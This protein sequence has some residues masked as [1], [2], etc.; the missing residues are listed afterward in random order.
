MESERKGQQSRARERD[1]RYHY[2]LG[3]FRCGE[4]RR[5]LMAGRGKGRV[6]ARRERRKEKEKRKE[7]DSL[8]I[9]F[10]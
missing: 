5:S 7:R 1:R 4:R 10:E 8:S 9:N 6:V 2:F 3:V